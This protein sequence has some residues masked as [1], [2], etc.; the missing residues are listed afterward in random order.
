MT[1]LRAPRRRR[2]PLGPAVGFAFFIFFILLFFYGGSFLRGMFATLTAQAPDPAYALLSR[3]ALAS[4]LHDAEQELS[5]IRY[6][7]LL[8][9]LVAEENKELRG[10][11]R[12]SEIPTGIVA[13][14]LARPPRTHYD[15]LLVDVGSEKGMSV[16]DLAIFEGIG[17]GTVVTSD[18]RTSIISLFSTPG[19]ET[20]VIVGTPHAVAVA[21]GLGGGAFEVLLPQGIVVMP[22]DIVRL[23]GSESLV[24][25]IV[26]NVARAPAD[27]LQQVLFHS[28][29]SMSD[30]DFVRIVP[31][32]LKEENISA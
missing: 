32:F 17:L 22:G 23:P 26:S 6:Q 8:Y 1:L 19:F 15:T 18:T 27:V 24:V 7:A 9:A 30:L 2:I 21:H 10:L 5:R 11:L 25:G 29:V 12:A 16:G 28:P 3:S 31:S 14:V 4:R 20:D 13:R